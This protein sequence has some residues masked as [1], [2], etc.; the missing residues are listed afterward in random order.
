MHEQQSCQS[1]VVRML[2]GHLKAVDQVEPAIQNFW[3]FVEQRELAAKGA[4]GLDRCRGR[5]A[6]AIGRLWTRGN[7]SELHQNLST[8]EHGFLIHNQVFYGR[9]C[10]GVFRTL[11]IRQPQEHV[12]IEKPDH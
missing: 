3:S 6:Q 4:D 12:R 5:P 10:N 2:A 8:N 9:L 7:S 11:C 1:G